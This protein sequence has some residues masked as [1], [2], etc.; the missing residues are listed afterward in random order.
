MLEPRLDVLQA[1]AEVTADLDRR[2]SLALV[3]PPVQRGNR[4]MNMRSNFGRP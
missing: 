4:H 2:R 1:I 3:T